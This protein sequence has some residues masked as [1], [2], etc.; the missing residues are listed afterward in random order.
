MIQ[1]DLFPGEAGL[2]R[3]WIANTCL[4]PSLRHVRLQPARASPSYLQI[5]SMARRP[6]EWGCTWHWLLTL[7][8]RHC[9][10]YFK[11]KSKAGDTTWWIH[12]YISSLHTTIPYDDAFISWAYL[13]INPEGMFPYRW[14]HWIYKE[15]ELLVLGQRKR[16]LDASAY[17]AA[18][19][20]EIKQGEPF[21][22]TWV[23]NLKR[24]RWVFDIF[25]T[26]SSSIPFL[27]QWYYDPLSSSL[28]SLTGGDE[29][30]PQNWGS[31]VHL[32][33]LCCKGVQPR[34]SELGISD[35]LQA[36]YLP[37]WDIPWGM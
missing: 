6:N 14:Y 9:R 8:K 1:V 2:A 18:N 30:F 19:A 13:F 16:T 35:L 11:H 33:S 20:V 32:P 34:S 17:E 7:V 25:C 4:P 5:R 15:L 27:R 28:G 36:S 12:T 21:T 3:T 37:S 29:R 22:A 31:K 26:S 23:S 10:W 24:W